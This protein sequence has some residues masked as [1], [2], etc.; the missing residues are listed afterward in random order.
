MKIF[1]LDNSK[2]LDIKHPEHILAPL[3]IGYAVSLLEKKGHDS[4]FLDLRINRLS[5]KKII[6]LLKKKKPDV[7]LIKPGFFSVD[8]AKKISV[9]FKSLIKLIGCYGPIST[10]H[11]ERFLYENSK[12]DFCILG[13]V[14]PVL[15]S[16]VDINYISQNTSDNI[17]KIKGIAFFNKKIIINNPRP[18]KNLND[19]PFPKQELFFEK[20]YSLYYPV[21]RYSL[22]K[23]GVVLSSRG[24]PYNCRFCSAITKGYYNHGFRARSPL[25]VVNELEY[26]SEIGYNTIY[27][28]DDNFSTDR[29]RALD[30]CNLIIKRKLDKKIRW[31]AQ[32][33]VDN[34]DNALLKKMK[35]AG[36]TTVCLGIESGSD[37][38]LS[39]MN[40]GFDVDTIL[41][42]VKLLRKSKIWLVANFIL[43]SPKETKEDTLKS[44]GLAGK[45][46]PEVLDLHYHKIY[47]DTIVNFI[48]EF[49]KSKLK[50]KNIDEFSFIRDQKT[51]LNLSNLSSNELKCLYNQ[52]YRRYYFQFKYIFFTFPKMLPY[53]LLNIRFSYKLFIR[54]IRTFKR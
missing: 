38:I 4:D 30:I 6:E 5:F 19:L 25:N 34:I 3:D 31:I 13:D 18:I 20:G 33:R 23:P 45:I 28:V 7:L 50:D 16:L 52:F 36:C 46:N 32:I 39:N 8:F 40:K 51:S 11:P 41:K 53:Y 27:F 2:N 24:C 35:R 43:G 54:A 29:K 14:E 15:T 44:I 12:I 37:K 1:F 17:K 26:M 49:T 42:K 9:S 10:T 22:S 21:N 48:P 47:S